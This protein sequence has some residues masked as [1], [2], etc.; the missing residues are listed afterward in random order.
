MILAMKMK[1]NSKNLLPN[2]F[3]YYLFSRFRASPKGKFISCGSN[4]LY[5]KI[6]RF[7]VNSKVI[8]TI[9]DLEHLTCEYNV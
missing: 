8:N 4:K 5:L 1:I 6:E 7:I 9:N 3:M 2:N